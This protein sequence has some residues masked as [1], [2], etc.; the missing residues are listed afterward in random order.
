MV[1][2]F[3]YFLLLLPVLLLSGCLSKETSSAEKTYRY[4]AGEDAP[5]ELRLLKGKYWESP[6]FTKE[7]IMFLEIQAPKSWVNSFIALNK[8]A[9][10]KDS[11]FVQ[12]SEAPSWFKPTKRQIA[13]EPTGFSQGST[14]FIDTLSGHMLIYEIQ[15]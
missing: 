4:W 12:P 10:S 7:Y 11:G 15:L 9:P 14:Y 2:S 13:F 5:R 8:L 1:H 3:K 6:H